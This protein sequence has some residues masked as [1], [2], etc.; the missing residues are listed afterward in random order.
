M[1]EFTSILLEPTGILNFFSER[2]LPEPG[3]QI[4]TDRTVFSFKEG[5]YPES[6]GN[7]LSELH[8]KF[9]PSLVRL[10]NVPWVE[11][12]VKQLVQRKEMVSTAESCTGGGIGA[13][14]TEIP[15]SSRIYWGGCITYSNDAKVR[16][17]GVPEQVLLERG[18]VSRETVSIM[19]KQATSLGK[20]QWAIAVSGIAGPSGGTAEKPVGTVY[21]ALAGPEGYMRVEKIFFRGTRQEIRKKAALLSLLLLESSV[22]KE[23]DIDI[24]G[25]NVYI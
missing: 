21:I 10:G 22:C 1:F 17:L 9:P 2:G 19:A 3:Y 13:L 16:L 8:R 24:E 11:N 12:L 18:A 23:F 14:L 25:L 5:S 4:Y 15:G 6:V 20:T 7:L